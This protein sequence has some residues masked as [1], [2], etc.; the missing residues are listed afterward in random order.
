MAGLQANL[1]LT[2]HCQNIEPHRAEQ[3]NGDANDANDAVSVERHSNNVKTVL[4]LPAFFPHLD[5]KSLI[6]LRKVVKV[7]SN[8]YAYFAQRVT[9]KL[10]P[11]SVASLSEGG[12]ILCQA[13]K[14]DPASCAV[15]VFRMLIEKNALIKRLDLMNCRNIS[16]VIEVFSE[17]ELQSIFKNCELLSFGYIGNTEITV[18]ALQKILLHLRQVK[19]LCARGKNF[20]VVI[21]RLSDDE[22]QR[23]FRNCEFLQLAGTDITVSAFQKLFPYLRRTKNI[24]F[25]E[26]KNLS[27]I[28]T[29]LTDDELQSFFE[30]CKSLNLSFSDITVS[31]LQRLLPYLVQ[32]K[33]LNL[34]GCKNLSAV[35][36]VL[37]DAVLQRIFGGLERLRVCYTEITVS[38]LK[39][40]LPHLA[41]VKNLDLAHC[42][43]LSAAIEALPAALQRSFARCEELIL[44]NSK[45]T[46][47]ALKK[48][49]PHLGLVKKLDLARC[50]NLPDVLKAYTDEQL[51]EVFRNCEEVKCWDANMSDA[52]IGRISRN[53]KDSFFK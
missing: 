21:E 16:S 4:N 32:A 44:R 49:L 29:K 34:A 48:L 17:G 18:S 30:G 7:D 42:E 12:N 46:V 41:M 1:P 8:F 23:I 50:K 47:S 27:D 43:N 31:A 3:Y 53:T 10:N 15:E 24:S 22:L 28:I 33:G 45:I 26:C 20:S 52:D 37:P 51:Y 19:S 38:A 39:K 25:Q 5:S 14:I 11:E 6:S 35:I 2:Q 9:L 13:F 40:I 36:E